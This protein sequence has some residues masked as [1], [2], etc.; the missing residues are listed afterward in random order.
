M[1][2]TIPVAHDFNCGW[3][4]VGI[5]QIQKL[6]EE[7]GVNFEYLSY[8]LYPPELPW[9][10]GAPVVETSNRPKTPTRFQLMLAAEG[11]ELPPVE[12]PKK[13]RTHLAHLATQFALRHYRGDPF[14]H[15]LYMAYW[16]RGEMIDE[17]EFL[18][19]TG[20]R[21]DLDPK[22]MRQAIEEERDADRIVH[23]DAPA[24]ASGV[25]NVPTY[26]LGGER[27]AEQPYR[28]LQK[29]VAEAIGATR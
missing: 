26:F 25:Y 7:F 14:I 2:L 12:R 6:K 19:R 20:E 21:F 24:Y 13:M 9:P 1:S 5:V 28:V 23:F 15:E 17:I 22:E 11:M 4:Y 18:T 10:D 16:E 29:A 27:Y 3:C 8:E